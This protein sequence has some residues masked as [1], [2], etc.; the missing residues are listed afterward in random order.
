[1]TLSRF[2]AVALVAM[3]AKSTSASALAKKKIPLRAF[4]EGGLL[5]LAVMERIKMI[6]YGK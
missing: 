1:M 5:S 6:N 4:P 3:G 2:A